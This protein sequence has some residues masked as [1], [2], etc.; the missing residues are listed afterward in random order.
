MSTR[1]SSKRDERLRRVLHDLG[2][3]ED[4]IAAALDSGYF[5]RDWGSP[6]G[7]TDATVSDRMYG[8]K[9]FSSSFEIEG[10][11]RHLRGEAVFERRPAFVE[12]TVR[13]QK[14]LMA[15]LAESPRQ[16][17]LSNGSLS[18]RG[19]PKEYWLKRRVPNPRRSDSNGRELSIL[20][21]LYRQTGNEY[22]FAQPLQE[23]KPWRWI[24]DELEPNA[25]NSTFASA[26]A[27]DIMRT[28]QHYATQTP[29]LDISFDIRTALFFA[30]YR[31]DW[32]QDGTAK[33][34]RVKRGDHQGVI[35]CFRFLDPRV[36]E[37]EFLIRDFDFFKTNRPERIL[38]QRCGLPLI[39]EHERNIAI[40]DIDCII[41]LAAD[42]DYNPRR[43]PMYLFPSIFEDKFYAA[44]LALKERYPEEL[45]TVVEYEF[46]RSKPNR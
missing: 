28:E 24:L 27:Y 25:E 35:Y 38:R 5:V 15:V 46:A 16:Q 13:N 2:V 42:F 7:Q 17:Y 36:T 41:R 14:E 20:P 9:Q 23:N 3:S 11:A 12:V 4:L 33:Y 31:F 26:Y 45:N 37:T 22:S 30:L 29:G 40:T 19:Q 44:L 8:N 39:G 21:G 34:T 6:T 1:S 32:K 18:F 43:S 10:F